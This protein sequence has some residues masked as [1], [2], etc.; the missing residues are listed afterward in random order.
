MENL[1]LFVR[2][3]MYHR[4]VQCRC[5]ETE[6]ICLPEN[7]Y[8]DNTDGQNGLCARCIKRINSLPLIISSTILGN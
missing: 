6:Y 8:Y 5:C 2:L 3:Q 4:L 1:T 7:D